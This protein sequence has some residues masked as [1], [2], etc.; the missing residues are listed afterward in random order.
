MRLAGHDPDGGH[1]AAALGASESARARGLLDLLAEGRVDVKQGIA[2]ALKQKESEIAARIAFLQSQVLDELA[3]GGRGALGGA[4][5]E[6]ELAQAEEDRERLEG[7]I[8]R[9][10]PHYAAV[11]DPIPL[12]VGQIQELLDPRTALLEYSV[13]EEISYLFVVTRDGLRGYPLPPA[14][15]LAKLVDSFRQAIHEPSRLLYA[16]YVDAAQRLYQ[17]LVA[18]AL[19]SLRDKPHLIVS[20]DGPLLLLSFEALLTASPNPGGAGSLY[21][22]LPYLIRERSVTY[23]PSASVLAELARSNQQ[24]AEPVAGKAFLGFGDPEYGDAGAPPASDAP[25]LPA[26]S[27]ERFFQTAGLSRPRRLAASRQEVLDIAALYSPELSEVHLGADAS[28][29]RVKNS[30][31]LKSARRIHFAVHGFLDPR[32]PARSGLILAREGD[33][34]GEDGLLQV[35]EIFNLELDADLVVLSA[36]DTALGNAVMG[37]GL[38]GMTRAFLYA[39]AASVVVSLWQVS[40][41]STA[42]LMVSFYRHLNETEDTAEALRLAK[43]ELI[44]KGL[45]H[46]YHWAPVILIGRPQ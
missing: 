27:V 32:Q 5:L 23:A 2:P 38:I 10:H 20:P 39:G 7:Q 17:I 6:A 45:D 46:P 4:R 15:E 18:P 37:E 30:P 29:D 33:L 22:D 13:G 40:D 26:G 28:E 19:G 36:C 34:R 25:E 24:A 3:G 43:L 8:R 42:E 11:R 21:G 44:R 12:Q 1:V 14:A 31:S 35:Y 9:E 41:T 16:R